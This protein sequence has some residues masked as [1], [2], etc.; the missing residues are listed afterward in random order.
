M[1][2]ITDRQKVGRIGEHDIF[3]LK[4]YLI[5]PLSPNNLGLSEAQVGPIELGMT[6]RLLSMSTG[7]RTERCS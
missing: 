6:Q 2:V 5:M 3:K 1:I 7:P 4:D